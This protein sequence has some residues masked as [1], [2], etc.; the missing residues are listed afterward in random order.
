MLFCPLARRQLNRFEKSIFGKIRMVFNTQ[1]VRLCVVLL[2]CCNFSMA[3]SEKYSNAT[4][5]PGSSGIPRFL[6]ITLK[7]IG[8]C[9][10]KSLYCV[11]TN[12]GKP[13]ENMR[14]IM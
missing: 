6:T 10:T 14:A 4:C 3:F 8:N 13:F 11:A 5:Q 2:Y 9:P 1:W 7:N 12:E